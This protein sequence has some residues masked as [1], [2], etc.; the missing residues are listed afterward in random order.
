[1]QVIRSPKIIQKTS[2]AL[3]RRGQTI[4]FVPT[5]GF[6]H[7]GHITL[8]RRA[9]QAGDVVVLSIFVNPTQFGPKEDFKKYPR[10][11]KS[12]LKKAAAAGVDFV[13][14]PTPSSL[15]ADS[16]ETYL[17]V[18]NAT[19]ELCGQF[20]PGHFRGV[21]TIVAKLFNLIQ[22]DIAFFG[23]K[24][25]QQ[26]AVIRRMVNDLNFP[27]K[28]IGVD[29]V[30][31]PDGLA[32]SSRN[33]YLNDQ[34]RLAALCLSRGLKKIKTAVRGGKKDLKKLIGILQQEI[35][36][37]PSVKIQYVK[38]VDKDSIQPLAVYRPGKTLFA[39]AVFIGKTR[40]IDNLVV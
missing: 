34:Q 35:K 18:T 1:M 28:I 24:D 16:F 33:V 25:F 14:A 10:D 7:E 37:E 27:V 13:F 30:R 39:V 26:Y 29:T 8:L 22:P 4:A 38:A 15:Y 21:T 5:M 40:L 20:R 2:L 12:D 31:E 9:R 32:M 19:R 11:M 3:K 17:E 6:L 36:R 23:K